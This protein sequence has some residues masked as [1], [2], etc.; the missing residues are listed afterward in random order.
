LRQSFFPFHFLCLLSKSIKDD[1]QKLFFL[2][3]KNKNKENAQGEREGERLS[4]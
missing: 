2:S 1:T 4:E 3:A